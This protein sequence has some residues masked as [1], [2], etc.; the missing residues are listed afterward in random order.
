MTLQ[1]GDKI[2]YN[3]KLWPS[4][5]PDWRGRTGRIIAL[6]EPPPA[7]GDHLL[8]RI[9]MDDGEIRDNISTTKLVRAQAS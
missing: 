9:E 3:P 6:D 2:Q 4:G 7:Q 5:S 8:A 1:I